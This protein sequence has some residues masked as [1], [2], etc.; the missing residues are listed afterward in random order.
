[1]EVF[2]STYRN[3]I[4]AKGRISVPAP[5]R[6][7]LAKQGPEGGL[8]LGPDWVS[9]AINESRVLVA[10]GTNYL[11]GVNSQIAALPEFSAER[12]DLEDTLLASLTP[13]S[14]DTEG[15]IVLPQPLIEHAGLAAAGEAVFVGRG[16]K[17][18]IWEPKAWDVRQAAARTATRARLRRGDKA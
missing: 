16:S 9:D 6:A 1:M 14:L 13:V 5:F 10:G 12:A 4:D 18:L 17:F 11:N 15:R 8:Y 7:V 3:R 2:L